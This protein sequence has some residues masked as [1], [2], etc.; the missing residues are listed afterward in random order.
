LPRETAAR[1]SEN[2]V[3]V[4]RRVRLER[5]LEKG[6]LSENMRVQPGDVITVPAAVF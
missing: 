5:L 3:P 2:G 1:S 6:D 4:E